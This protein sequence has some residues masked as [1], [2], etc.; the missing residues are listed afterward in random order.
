MR[1]YPTRFGFLTLVFGA[2]LSVAVLSARAQQ[3][4]GMGH[5]GRTQPGDSGGHGDHG[6]PK[7][8]KFT[9]PKGDPA[10]G[11]EV[12][13]KLECYSCHEVRGET[14]PAPSEPGKVG[15]ELSAM[16]PLHE[17]E[18]FA[19][20]IINPNA[21]IEQGKGYSAPG[22]LVQDA[23]VQR[24]GH[25]PG[26]GGPGGVPPIAQAACGSPRRPRA[27]ALNPDNASGSLAR[28]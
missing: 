14:F 6:T 9:W 17:P 7:D 4:P 8:W 18:Y 13:M 23:V 28:G 2:V 20:T 21:V 11:R 26:S 19:E 12:F 27:R 5:G 22:R 10:K 3:M 25:G 15:P 1:R 24:R 16:G